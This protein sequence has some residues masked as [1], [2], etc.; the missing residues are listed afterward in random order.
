MTTPHCRLG[1]RALSLDEAPTDSEWRR[2]ISSSKIPRACNIGS[3]W[4][5][6]WNLRATKGRT[7]L[8]NRWEE[9]GFH[10]CDGRCFVAPSATARLSWSKSAMWPASPQASLLIW[11]VLHRWWAVVACLWSSE[12]KGEWQRGPPRV[13]RGGMDGVE[14]NPCCLCSGA[15]REWSGCWAQWRWE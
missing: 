4:L 3:G 12:W 13:E 6:S 5:P 1:A 10:C 14:K 11:G 8:G 2:N 9:W 7:H 15:T